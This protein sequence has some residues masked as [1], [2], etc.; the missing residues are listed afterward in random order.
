MDTQIGDRDLKLLMEV[1]RRRYRDGV[2]RTIPFG[3]LDS[4]R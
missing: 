3:G 1:R 4:P 2:H